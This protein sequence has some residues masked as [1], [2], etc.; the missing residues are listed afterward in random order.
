MGLF[1]LLRQPDI[2]EGSESKNVFLQQLDNRRHSRLFW[3]GGM[4]V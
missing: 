3:K 1:D 2:N 4:I